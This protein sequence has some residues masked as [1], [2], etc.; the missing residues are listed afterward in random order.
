MHSREN[1]R[2]AKE[3][4]LWRLGSRIA[5]QRGRKARRLEFLERALDL[6]FAQLPDVIDGEQVKKEY[7]ML[8]DH[9]Q[10]LAEALVALK[11]APPA[12]FILRVIRTAD[13]WRLA[14]S[15]CG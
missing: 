11:Q 9:Y 7:G 5:E 8:L 14:R 1:A 3:P 10:S 2:W 4:E 6:E 15:G 13:R 12:D